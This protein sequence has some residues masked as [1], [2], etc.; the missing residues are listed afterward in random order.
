MGTWLEFFSQLEC[1]FSS[2]F[3]YKISFIAHK[4]VLQFTQ[5]T[6]TYT[7]A[8]NMLHKDVKKMKTN[9]KCIIAAHNN[10]TTEL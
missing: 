1:K 6:C 8:M 4:H 9:T 7:T 5:R 10:Y 3:Y 2:I